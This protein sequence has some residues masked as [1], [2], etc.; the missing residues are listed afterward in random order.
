MPGFAEGG[1]GPQLSAGRLVK[2]APLAEP[3]ES[4][5]ANHRGATSAE[6]GVLG[7]GPIVAGLSGSGPLRRELEPP[8]RSS[9]G[10]NVAHQPEVGAP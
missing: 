10:W 1:G 3:T 7:H 5:S 9:Q 4:A 8:G 2:P 6:S